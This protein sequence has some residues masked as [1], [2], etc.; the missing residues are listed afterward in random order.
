M[1]SK[2]I[3]KIIFGS[4]GTGKSHMI[5][6]EI[7]PYEL[8]IDIKKNPENIIKAVFHP[9]YT[10]GDFM[11][12]LLPMTQDGQVEYNFYE[13]HFLSALS[14]A[15]K[16]ILVIGADLFSSITDYTRRDSVF[17]G[18]GAGAAKGAGRG[19]EADEGWSMDRESR[20]ERSRDGRG[21]AGMVSDAAAARGRA[22]RFLVPQRVRPARQKLGRI[23]PFPQGERLQRDSAEHAVGRHGLLSLE[24]FA[25]IR[26]AC[27][28]R[29]PAG[30]VSGGLPEIR[31]AMPC[32][33][34][35]LEHVEQSA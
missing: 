26:A 4:P 28:K 22:S 35:E 1:I 6:H 30:A 11:G 29:R 2:P 24:G 27:R 7:I 12:K 20:G 16:N 3:Q 34:S 8:N 32:V 19:A 33:E 31:R 18:D 5:D 17:F 15:Y 9:E 14:Q 21:A 25:G 23:D 13:G 10:H